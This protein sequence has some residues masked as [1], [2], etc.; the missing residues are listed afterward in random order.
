M[1]LPDLYICHP[2]WGCRWVEIKN[3]A[4]YSFT[5]AQK[6]K[7]PVLER[8]GVGIWILT[9]A[10]QDNYNRLFAAPNWRDYVNKVWSVPMPQE[11]DNMLEGMNGD[12]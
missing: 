5:A 6:R 12:E 10:D 8:Y 9:G 3:A 1:G 7:W 4:R 2:K 11:I